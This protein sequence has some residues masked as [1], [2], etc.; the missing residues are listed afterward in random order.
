MR[1]ILDPIISGEIGLFDSELNW[2]VEGPIYST[3]ASGSFDLVNEYDVTYIFRSKNQPS[4]TSNCTKECKRTYSPS[5]IILTTYTCNC[6]WF[7]ST[8][9]YERRNGLPRN[10]IYSEI[11]RVGRNES[12]VDSIIASGFTFTGPNGELLDPE[13]A[14]TNSL[15][16]IFGLKSWDDQP[17]ELIHS[18]SS[19]RF[20]DCLQ[21]GGC[22][23]F[24]Q[25]ELYSQCNFTLLKIRLESAFNFSYL[26]FDFT[27]GIYTRVNHPCVPDPDDDDEDDDP[28]DP[29]DQEFDQRCPPG[30]EVPEGCTTT[31]SVVLSYTTDDKIALRG[32]IIIIPAKTIQTRSFYNSESGTR[33]CSTIE[34]PH[35]EAYSYEHV[36]YVD[37]GFDV[38][39]WDFVETFRQKACEDHY[40]DRDNVDDEERSDDRPND[41]IDKPCGLY[42]RLEL[43]VG[44]EF[45]YLREIPGQEEENITRT[46]FKMYVK[47]F[48]V[49]IP[50][51]LTNSQM[52]LIQMLNPNVEVQVDFIGISISVGFEIE[53]AGVELTNSTFNWEFTAL[54]AVIFPQFAPALVTLSRSPVSPFASLSLIGIGRHEC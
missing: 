23:S 20:D 17:M 13:V 53:I 4:S 29:D 45:T 3:P 38:P 21:I 44:I 52:E 15:L 32:N 24:N 49:N 11:R 35:G 2:T 27:E 43:A 5:D 37:R 1:W 41:D 54:W 7:V 34:I 46:A 51:E 14:F 10:L 26:G 28:D 16:G 39:G 42:L 12:F 6:E 47:E 25:F 48:F 19:S 18:Y 9:I 8:F 50:L 40:S 30:Y 36:V 22:P 31:Q 33:Q